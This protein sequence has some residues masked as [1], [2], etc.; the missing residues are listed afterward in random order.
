MKIIV[1]MPTGEFLKDSNGNQIIDEENK[2]V[3]VLADKEFEAPFI[4]A[5]KLKRTVII[6][7]KMEKDPNGTDNLDIMADYISDIFGRQFSKDETLDGL[8]PVDLIDEFT[9][10]IEEV[11]G[12]LNKKVDKLAETSP[13]V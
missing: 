1:K 5:R 11:T 7:T 13:N 4:S 6:G 12:D 3:P 9:R 10:C 2:P 8:K